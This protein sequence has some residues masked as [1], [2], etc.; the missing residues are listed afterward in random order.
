[1]VYAIVNK[2]IQIVKFLLRHADLSRL[3][4]GESYIEKAIKANFTEGALLLVRV[5]TPTREMFKLALDRGEIRL[6][7]EIAKSLRFKW[8][9]IPDFSVAVESVDP[10]LQ[11]K[12]RIAIRGRIADIYDKAIEEPAIFALSTLTSIRNQCA[13]HYLNFIKTV[14]HAWGISIDAVHPETKKPIDSGGNSPFKSLASWLAFLSEGKDSLPEAKELLE[15]FSEVL[16]HKMDPDAIE[17]ADELLKKGKTVVCLTG[18]DL[19]TSY[20]IFKHDYALYAN[21]GADCLNSGISVYQVPCT[22]DIIKSIRS[23]VF[24][25]TL[26]REDYYTETDMLIDLDLEFICSLDLQKQKHP[27]CT[28]NS[29]KAASLGAMVLDLIDEEKDFN[30][31]WLT[32]L[33]KVK[34]AYKTLTTEYRLYILRGVFNEVEDVLKEKTLKS[35]TASLYYQILLALLTKIESGTRFDASKKKMYGNQ[36]KAYLNRLVDH[37]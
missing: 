21:R 25:K 3:I 2:E 5:S 29:L 31:D 24:D 16:H 1:F 37:L 17:A 8:E 34:P 30:E 35:N 28:I 18:F 10:D 26:E 19:H 20:A 23:L 6:A 11:Q 32:T 12:A 13:W 7:L 14:S 22:D 15:Q 9:N 4:G 27:H 33:N 36:I